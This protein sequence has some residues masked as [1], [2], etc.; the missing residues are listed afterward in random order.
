MQG[1]DAKLVNALGINLMRSTYTSRQQGIAERHIKSIIIKLLKFCEKDTHLDRWFPL[2]PRLEF[3]HGMSPHVGL[4]MRTPFEVVYRR[5]PHLVA[6]ITSVEAV[7]ENFKRVQQISEDVRIGAL[8]AMLRNKETGRE[9]KVLSEGQLFFRKRLSFATNLNRKLQVKLVQAFKV[10][11]RIATSLYQ[12]ENIVNGD[13]V[14][15][16]SDQMVL[17]NLPIERVKSIISSLSQ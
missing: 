11:K 4:N 1:I 13:V 10:I 7:E 17:T 14:I 2:L 9:E 8:R 3:S 16:P 12:V 6:S 5:P 15:I